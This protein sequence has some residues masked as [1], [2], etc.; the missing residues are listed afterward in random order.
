MSYYRYFIVSTVDSKGLGIHYQYNYHPISYEN[1][2]F[3]ILLPCKCTVMCT[4]QLYIEQMQACAVQHST[5]YYS[6]STAILSSSW[7]VLQSTAVQ[8]SNIE[9]LYK[10]VLQSTAVQYSYIAG[11]YYRVQL[12][13][14]A[15]YI[16]YSCRPVLQSTA[17][18][19]TAACLCYT[20]LLQYSFRVALS[21]L[22]KFK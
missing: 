3:P 20:V 7:S 5:Q 15:I 9:H 18:Y 8:Y 2:Y 1:I 17:V 14:T 21:L 11:L 22:N 19:S 16:Q 10:L 13:S 12:C 4:V 6:C